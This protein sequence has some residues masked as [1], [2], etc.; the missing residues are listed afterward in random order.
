MT[1]QIEGLAIKLAEKIKEDIF[2]GAS[3][4]EKLE[5]Q[6]AIKMRKSG[7]FAKVKESEK[8]AS[9]TKTKTV[10][11]PSHGER[12]FAENPKLMELKQK[13]GN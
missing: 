3:R 9:V 10:F 8:R 1:P 6:G 4:E 11:T 2:F 12:T 7:V 13:F 5:M